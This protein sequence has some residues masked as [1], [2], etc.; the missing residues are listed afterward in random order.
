MFKS[1]KPN[2]TIIITNEKGA[3]LSSIENRTKDQVSNFLS[4]MEGSSVQGYIRCKCNEKYYFTGSEV[5]S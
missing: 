2:Y 4:A 5:R 1:N 3:T